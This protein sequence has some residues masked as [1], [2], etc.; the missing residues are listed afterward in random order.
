[1]SELLCLRCGMKVTNFDKH[2]CLLGEPE[3]HD[4]RCPMSKWNGKM[5]EPGC[6]CECRIRD[7]GAG[8]LICETHPDSHVRA[9]TRE[10]E[11]AQRK[12]RG[13]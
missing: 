3:L 13:Q 6:T 4:D 7:F 11:G 12:G 2:L 10:C 5:K 1:M 9:D 8:G